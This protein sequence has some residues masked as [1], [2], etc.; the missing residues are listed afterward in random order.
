M[1]LLGA[2][3]GWP[4]V[5]LAL[6]QA[7]QVVLLSWINVRQRKLHERINGGIDDWTE[8]CAERDAERAGDPPGVD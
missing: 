6:I 3:P 5:A 2:D 8:R 7:A 4:T 1:D